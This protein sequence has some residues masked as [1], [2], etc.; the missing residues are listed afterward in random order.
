MAFK[1]QLGQDKYKEIAALYDEV[2]AEGF[3]K[4]DFR[5]VPSFQEWVDDYALKNY[6]Q[7]FHLS[8][9]K[10]ITKFLKQ[11]YRNAQTSLFKTLV[12]EA[13]DGLKLVE[14]RDLK[15]LAGMS[16]AQA[17]SEQAWNVKLDK[18]RDKVKKA[19]NKLSNATDTPVEELFD[20]TSKV[21]KETGVSVNETSRYLTKLPE[22]KKFKP[23]I[24]LL[25]LPQSKAAISGKKL[26]LG[27][28]VDRIE[29]RGLTS[30]MST[31]IG[32]T[33]E[34][35]IIRSALR[36][37]EQG[38]DKIR[39]V[40]KPGTI[41]RAGDYITVTDAEF[42]YK[43]K[44]YNYD[45][46]AAR[47][48]KI[49]EFKEVYK[50]FD[51]YNT[52]MSKLVDHP[53]T[54]KKVK[55]ST[56]MKEAY[57][58]GAGYSYFRTPYA[59]D[60]IKSVKTEPFSNL[61]ILPHRINTGAG[62]IDRLITMSS[63]GVLS[64]EKTSLYTPEFKE[65]SLS[66]IG[67]NFL[68][69]PTQ[70]VEDELKL[71]KDI[72][73]KDRKLRTPAKIA[74]ESF[75]NKVK[76]TPGGCQA[77]VKRALGAKGGLFG[78]TC[79]TIIKAD[80][81]RA[82][83]KLNNAITATKG[84]LKN[85][86]D[87]SQ[88]LIRLF[89]GESFT[90]RNIKALKDRGKHWGASLAEM[91]KDTLSGQW[92]TPTQTH[93]SS[94]LSRPGQMKYVDVT[95][96]ELESFNR[97]KDKVNKRPVKY[98]TKK[99]LGLPDA[100]THGVTESFHHQIIPRYKLKE[101]E[102]AGRLKTKW[103]LNPLGER[104]ISRKLVEP[105]KGILEYDEVLGGFVDSANP[106]EVVG[107]NQLKAWAQDNP[108]PVKV[109]EAAPGILKKTGKALAHLGLPLPTAAM[110]AYFIGREIEEGKSP[111]EIAR[112]PLNWLGLATM[113]PLTR[114]A[115][116]A[117]KSG[118]LASVMRLGMS[119]GLI[120]GATRF[121]GLPGLALSTGLTAYDQYQKY[122]NKEG[123]IYDLFNREEI[124]NAQV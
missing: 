106:S 104:Y 30:G 44:N 123:F 115:G 48:R 80:P 3:S 63:K 40:K 96:Q 66:K 22:Y 67:Y 55:F 72:L 28:L 118:K 33:P 46:L 89:R 12:K 87:D 103:D 86:K 1:K 97:Y 6:N 4:R 99:K 116:M 83:V 95:P 38:G 8:T 107:Q 88:K 54:G 16:P 68:K 57:N 39:F 61:R 75:I 70:L 27:D 119:P 13:N 21:A 31:S 113:D 7:K 23:V 5:K 49:P 24:N 58:K 71:A 56:L 32:N 117:E 100:P 110:D 114:A 74:V 121:L 34:N 120:R 109:G 84:P 51:D 82:A 64:P 26:T 25:N 91:K 94:Y 124:D 79:E 10:R 102:K 85:L 111:E 81:E 45:T 105:P 65:K 108:M 98:S 37:T 90:Q 78:E 18:A 20:F 14:R 29:N 11:N 50:V 43:G 69:T 62:G 112:N 53:V 52:N 93:A 19:F 122:K 47:G 15:I 41:T 73:T 59:I 77:V 92:F 36:H 9:K 35:F 42:N 101:M 60:H 17:A 76:S 2:I